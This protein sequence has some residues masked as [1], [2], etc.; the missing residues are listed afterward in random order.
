MKF[1]EDSTRLRTRA[2]TF[3]EWLANGSPPRAASRAFMSVRLIVLDKHPDVQ[4]VGIG[5]ITSC[6]PDLRR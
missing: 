4:P 6:V 3:V 5:E 2:K 1:E